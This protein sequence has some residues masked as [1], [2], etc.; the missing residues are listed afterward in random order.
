MVITK[1]PR[2]NKPLT[3]FAC[4]ALRRFLDGKFR[5]TDHYKETRGNTSVSVDGLVFRTYLYDQPI[6][7]ALVADGKVNSV[8]VSFTSTY[9]SAGVP[10]RTVRERLNGLLDTLGQKHV[11]PY[12]VRIFIDPAYEV[13]Y[14]GRGDE[15]IAVGRDLVQAVTIAPSPDFLNISHIE[16]SEGPALAVSI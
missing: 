6:F 16:F 15:R 2:S 7:T 11:L 12:N 14:L 10:T 8:Q 3:A 9:D 13:A 5:P 4:S 1:A